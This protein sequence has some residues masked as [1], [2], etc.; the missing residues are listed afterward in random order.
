MHMV[1]AVVG[2]LGLRVVRV[3]GLDPVLET[4]LTRY[5]AGGLATANVLQVSA[6]PSN[7][8]PLSQE[9]WV[10]HVWNNHQG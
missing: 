9:P 6:S 1:V 7:L 10:N 4:V 3:G 5:R 8:D 2:G